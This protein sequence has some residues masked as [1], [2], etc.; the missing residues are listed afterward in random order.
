MTNKR[1]ALVLGGTS[2]HIQLIKSLKLRGY[3][4]ILLDYLE[5]PPAKEY[6]DKH[7]R[8]STTDK[9]L[10]L[11]VAQENKVDLVVATSIESA[12]LTAIYVSSKLNLPKHI[13][14][15][16]ALE[17]T[18]KKKMKKVFFDNDIPSAQYIITNSVDVMDISKLKFPLVIKPVD[19]SSSKGVVKIWH[20]KD[21]ISNFENTINYSLTKE[22]II[23]EFIE[24]DE[25]SVD[26][27]VIN[28][29]ANVLFISKS[30]K[31]GS[32]E[33]GFTIIGSQYPVGLSK[34]QTDLIN[35][36]AQKIATS[37]SLNN[38]P[39]LI[40]LIMTNEE[41][42]VIECSARL[43][44]GSKYSF[45]K[46]GTDFDL[47]DASIKQLHNET[48]ELKINP[49]SCLLEMIYIYC[50]PGV[51]KEY[52]GLDTLKEDGVIIE[53]FI[54]KRQGSIIKNNIDSSDRPVGLL[55]SALTEEE[56]KIKVAV[57]YKSLKVK[58][59]SGKN[60]LLNTL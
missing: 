18:N 25:I 44:G 55:I 46:Q 7:I 58:D 32:A 1:K 37:F 11:K 22:I 31:T 40:Q 60:L 15:E 10:V 29:K 56:L 33:L 20:K 35:S 13:S 4:T 53:Y 54:Y 43:G 36:I 8:E 12:L 21:L 19:S 51:I 28:G 3:Q 30:I 2:D 38:S 27:I 34:E 42:Y 9:E 17:I 41:V 50:K 47:L 26:C 59:P 52:E 48:V 57:I 5:N 23:E 39:L 45:I 24:G 49:S 16:K 14:Y 6:A